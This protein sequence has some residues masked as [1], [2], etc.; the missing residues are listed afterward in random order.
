MSMPDP[1]VWCRRCGDLHRPPACPVV[2]AVDVA[3]A[4][5][6]SASAFVDRIFAPWCDEHRLTPAERRVVRLLVDGEA[7][8]AE[9]AAAL[10][11]EETTVKCHMKSICLKTKAK[12]AR[13]VVV[14][15]LRAALTPPGRASG[16]ELA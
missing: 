15:V 1:V 14:L 10:G 3:S 13:D 4:M 2:S 7:S 6:G 9:L 16:K 11:V 12:N 5:P 8:R